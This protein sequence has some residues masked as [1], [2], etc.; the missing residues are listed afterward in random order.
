MG[1]K[2]KE[3]LLLIPAAFTDQFCVRRLL[4]HSTVPGAQNEQ[5]VW[6]KGK[7]VLLLA[8]ALAESWLEAS[9]KLRSVGAILVYADVCA[10][11]H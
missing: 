8:A 6:P 1:G 7:P 10:G 4:Q 5:L 3:K 2:K 9:V 11:C